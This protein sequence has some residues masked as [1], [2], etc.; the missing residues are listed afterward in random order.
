LP[1]AAPVR[2]GGHEYVGILVPSAPVPVGGAL[3]YVPTGWIRPA[4]GGVDELMTVYLSMGVTPPS[5]S[6]ALP[7]PQT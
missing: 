4:E 2:I 3:V 7:A 1:S 6:P 5:S